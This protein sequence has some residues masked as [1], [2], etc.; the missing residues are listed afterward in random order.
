MARESRLKP[1]DNDRISPL[2]QIPADKR[3]EDIAFLQTD[4]ESER[5]A[6]KEERFYWCFA[7][8]VSIDMAAFQHLGFIAIIAIFI[9]QL[10]LLVG[11]A[12]LFGVETVVVLIEKVL[13]ELPGYMRSGK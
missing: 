12:R 7:I 9:L 1:K 8:T 10:I 3:D 13:S 11:L 6:R 5:D 2:A 4:L